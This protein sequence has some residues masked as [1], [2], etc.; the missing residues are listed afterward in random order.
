MN[1]KLKKVLILL[2]I[3]V[4]AL[5]V[6]SR[7]TNHEVK[8][9][10]EDM[11]ESSLPVICAEI[12]GMTVNEMHGY[13]QQM[14]ASVMRDAIL[15]IR[16]GQPLA[17]QIYTYGRDIDSISYEIRSLDTER[18]VEEG[19]N[20]SVSKEGEIWE[21]QLETG[22]LLEKDTEYML[23]LELEQDGQS[24]YYYSRIM[25]EEGNGVEQSLEF[26]MD[27]H[28]TTMNEKE[29]S[30]LSRYLEPSS[31]ADNTTLQTVTIENSLSQ[32][33]WGSLS[34]QQETQPVASV[35]EIND[36]YTVIMIS[37]IISSENE[38]GGKDY[39]DVEE[40]YRIRPGEER[41]FLLNF[42]RNVNEIF[43]EDTAEISGEAI[44]LGIRSGDVDYWSGETGNVV[45]FVQEGDLWSYNRDN[46]QLTNVYSLRSEDIQDPRGT[47]DEHDIKIINGDEMG[48][49]DFIVYGYMNRGYHEGQVGISVCHYDSVT[50][51]VEEWLFIPANVSYQVMKEKI[52]QLMYISNDNIF[53]F[54]VGNAVHGIDLDTKDD[55]ILIDE[56]ADGAYCVSDDGRYVAWVRSGE[57]NTSEELNITDLDTGETFQIQAEA[58]SYIKPLGFTEND[59]IYGLARADDKKGGQKFP[60]YAVRISSVED[61]QETIEKTYEKE[62][63]YVRS[64]QVSE[65]TIYL[66]L[67]QY[68]DGRYQ[69]TGQDTITNRDMEESQRARIST[70]KTQDKQT[71]VILEWPQSSETGRIAERTAKMIIPDA[72]V[73]MKMDSGLF[74]SSYYVYAKGN[75]ILATDNVRTAVAAADSNMGVV[76]DGSMNYIWER[77]KASSREAVSVSEAD[78]SSQVSKAVNIMLKAVN[79]KADTDQLLA[80]GKEPLEILRENMEGCRVLDLTGCTLDQVLYYSGEGSLIYVQTGDHQAGIITGYNSSSV[81][82]Y[83]TDKDTQRKIGLEQAQEEFKENGSVYYTYLQTS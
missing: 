3:F 77:A 61:G 47:Y 6:F 72:S 81:W 48:S 50:N 46:H 37:G 82:V 69:N 38:D 7:L 45:C 13:V 53:Y 20:V 62:G 70:V 26:A 40:Y 80:E 17:L 76:V 14:D 60:M 36:S 43:Q 51:T 9:M 23:I 8:D 71:Q 74:T 27:F 73:E 25:P 33:G 83:D 15:P 24:V 16:S 18:L 59:C 35:K 31:D 10:T 32:I 12:N 65:G 21:A 19:D 52:E 22:D 54:T 63:T 34:V 79:E 66:N 11:P 29:L 49:V 67:M 2:G 1:R 58:G 78:G 42:E 68:R 41:M 57:I 30:S 64:I 5:I 39:Y 4:A 28:E 55:K 44:N 56:L 75:V